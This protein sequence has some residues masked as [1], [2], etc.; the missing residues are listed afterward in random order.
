MCYPV[1]IDML[2]WPDSLLNSL[3]ATTKRVLM[4][5]AGKDAP[6]EKMNGFV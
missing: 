3:D 2:H 1:M 4:Q 6:T 5:Q